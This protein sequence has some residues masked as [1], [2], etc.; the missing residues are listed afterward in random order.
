MLESLKKNLDINLKSY[1]L[2]NPKAL[3]ENCRVIVLENEIYIIVEKKINKERLKGSIAH[4]LGHIKM[5]S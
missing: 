2:F 4:E 1:L 3:E 5:H